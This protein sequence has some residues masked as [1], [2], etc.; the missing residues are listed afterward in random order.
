MSTILQP[1]DSATLP[2]NTPITVAG[3][4]GPVQR[5]KLFLVDGNQSALVQD[6]VNPPGGDTA[7]FNITLLAQPP[8]T[9][10]VV[11]LGAMRTSARSFYLQ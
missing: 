9:Y 3:Q 4:Q 2:A 11:V 8:G 7:I 10:V 5:I 6:V 1:L